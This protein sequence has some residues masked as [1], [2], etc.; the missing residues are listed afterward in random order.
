MLYHRKRENNYHLL[1]TKV[2][3]IFFKNLH[4]HLKE[5]KKRHNQI[6][7][8]NKKHDLSIFKLY[9]FFICLKAF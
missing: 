3:M 4:T 2:T 5:K 7:F 1:M 9:L 8:K 6:K